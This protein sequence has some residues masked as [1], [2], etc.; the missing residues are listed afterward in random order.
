VVGI[1]NVYLA[2]YK[3]LDGSVVSGP[4]VSDLVKA[5]SPETDARV[6]AAIDK[7]LS[8]MTALVERAKT[9]EAYDQMIGLENTE[10]NAV[11]QTAIDALVAQAKEL[12]RA[13]AALDLKDIKFEGSD[14]LDHP[15][16]V[17]GTK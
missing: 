16:K 13:I 9:V 12:E 5:K 7:T 6:K 1:Q 2:H 15:D 4:S 8:K 17:D 14:S 3:R 11:V 10:G